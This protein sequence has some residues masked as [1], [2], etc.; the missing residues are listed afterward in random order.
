MSVSEKVGCSDKLRDQVWGNTYLPDRI[1]SYLELGKENGRAAQVC[2]RWKV[3]T[4]R[5]YERHDHLNLNWL[6]TTYASDGRC[7]QVSVR[8][9]Q[10]CKNLKSLTLPCAIINQPGPLST[11][12]G[13]LLNRAGPVSTYRCIRYLPIF[14]YLYYHKQLETLDLSPS[15]PY[16]FDQLVY[17]ETMSFTAVPS[18]KRLI[19]TGELTH[20]SIDQITRKF[21]GLEELQVNGAVD[22]EHLLTQFASMKAL[23]TLLIRNNQPTGFLPASSTADSLA[24]IPENLSLRR[25]SVCHNSLSRYDSRLM[26]L[27]VVK[28]PN[29]ESLVVSTSFVMD[30]MLDAIF[31]GA[32]Q[33][34][35]CVKLARFN[36]EELAAIREKLKRVPNCFSPDAQAELAKLFAPAKQEQQATPT[37]TLALDA[38]AAEKQ[39]EDKK[40]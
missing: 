23:S 20:W 32:E 3:E 14:Q 7:G 13:A 29:L 40:E 18:L 19:T 12:R 22:L 10:T 21:P 4:E 39:Q 34:N 8:V 2:K 11:Y 5:Q 30:P 16:R 33:E 36:K 6:F 1:F 37:Q 26:K 31:A 9:L 28:M 27:L 17:F 24:A 38:P 35:G 15:H 25:V